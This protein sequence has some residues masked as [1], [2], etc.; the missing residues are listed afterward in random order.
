MDIYRKSFSYKERQQ[1]VLLRISDEMGIEGVSP[2][3]I[4]WSMSNSKVFLFASKKEGSA[5]VLTEA[6]N[7]GCQIVAR[8]GLSGGSYDNLDRKKFFNWHSK[9]EATEIILKLLTN[10]N[11]PEDIK[12]NIFTNHESVRKLEEFLKERNLPIPI[13][14]KNENQDLPDVLI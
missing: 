4:K 11:S 7:A 10:K 6:H 12:S 1:I 8:A 5:K 2:S 14:F 9:K 3:F 13:W